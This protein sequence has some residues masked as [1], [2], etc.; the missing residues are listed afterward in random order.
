MCGGTNCGVWSAARFVSLLVYSIINLKGNFM[1]KEEIQQMVPIFQACA[2]G[3]EVEYLDPKTNQW[4][5]L[6]VENID[7]FYSNVK[8]RVKNESLYSPFDV[9]DSHKLIGKVVK[10]KDKNKDFAVITSTSSLQISVGR[11]VIGYDDLLQHFTFFDD[12]PCGKVEL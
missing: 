7:A 2:R 8:Y 5:R 4:K 3:E 10:S 9:T 6:E 1:K 12:T 11:N